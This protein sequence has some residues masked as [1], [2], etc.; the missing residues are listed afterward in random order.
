MKNI[1]RLFVI[2]L[3]IFGCKDKQNKEVTANPT[4][5][6][7]GK[8]EVSVE[9]MIANLENSTNDDVIVVAHR[10]DWRNAP[11]NSLQ[12]VQ[13]AIDMGVDMVEIDVRETK[14]GELILMHDTTI[15]RTTTGEGKVKE[16]T[17]DSLRTL[18]L[19]DGLGIATPHTIPTL[20]EALELTKGKVLVNIDKGYDI[21]D[22]CYKV[23]Q[24]TSTAKQVVMKGGKTR[25]EVQEE[26]GEYLEEIYFMPILSL[27]NPEAPEIVEDYLENMPPVAFEF[28]VPNDTITFIEHFKSIRE[29]GSSIWVNSLWAHHNSGN[30]DEQAAMD[31]SVYDWFIENDI[32]II[33]TDRPELLLSYLRSKGFHK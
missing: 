19:R 11:E 23:I 33:Q 21:F 7:E 31:I 6:T 1:I 17:L 22:K 12:A 30:D 14:D 2:C 16:W 5:N 9:E 28:T 18:R 20:K 10:G 29:G 32:D 25:Q 3:F 4:V 24:E 27:E 13:F 15:G 26:F 8:Q